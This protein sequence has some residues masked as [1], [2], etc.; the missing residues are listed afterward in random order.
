MKGGAVW[1]NIAGSDRTTAPRCR[2]PCTTGK[3]TAPRRHRSCRLAAKGAIF[4]ANPASATHGEVWLAWG[5]RRGDGSEW[6][7]LAGTALLQTVDSGPRR[8]C[9][10][11][12]ENPQNGM[13]CAIQ[14]SIAWLVNQCNDSTSCQRHHRR[15]EPLGRAPRLGSNVLANS[16][17]HTEVSSSRRLTPPAWRGE[18]CDHIS[19]AGLGAPHGGRAKTPRLVHARSH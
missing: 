11:R 18:C 12:P 17:H 3:P 8:A 4:H 5:T 7:I 16:P 10:H 13:N 2:S 15:A 6:I 14:R 19:S 9:Q 1:Y